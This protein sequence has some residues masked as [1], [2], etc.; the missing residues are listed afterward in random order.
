MVRK[1][2]VSK[3]LC[4]PEQLLAL[5]QLV[6]FSHSCCPQPLFPRAASI[7]FSFSTLPK[8]ALLRKASPAIMLDIASE[9]V[10]ND[11]EP[12]VKKKARTE[13]VSDVCKKKAEARLGVI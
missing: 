10:W 13:L 3:V 12:E 9:S 4:D 11:E 6:A 2:W 5:I 1:E 7:E 8:Q